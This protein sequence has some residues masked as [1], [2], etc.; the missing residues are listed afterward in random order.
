M[1]ESLNDVIRRLKEQ[2]AHLQTERDQERQR[3][4]QNAE[5][6]NRNA[7]RADQ[8]KILTRSTTLLEFLNAAHLNLSLP[9]I[10]QFDKIWTTKGD[11]TN[12]TGKR[13]PKSIEK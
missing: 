6:T 11:Y 13:I 2:N 8:T 5:L 10:I 1:F 7:K 9:I 4:D 12:P 3:A